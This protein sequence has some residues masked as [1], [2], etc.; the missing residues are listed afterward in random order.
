MSDNAPVLLKDA[1]IHQLIAA[2]V[3]KTAGISLDVETM[4]G[5]KVKVRHPSKATLARKAKAAAKAKQ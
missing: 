5:S 2:L 3:E 1:N 4:G